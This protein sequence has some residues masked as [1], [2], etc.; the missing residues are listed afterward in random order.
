MRRTDRERER[1]RRERE[2]RERER[3]ERERGRR[4]YPSPSPDLLVDL[5]GWLNTRDEDFV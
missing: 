4:F 5:G 2:R 1:E 3:R